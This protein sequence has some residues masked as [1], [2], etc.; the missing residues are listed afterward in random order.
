MAHPQHNEQKTTSII[1]AKL[2]LLGGKLSLCTFGKE[3]EL[4]ITHDSNPCKSRG[5]GEQKPA[6]Q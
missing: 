4:V 3:I 6:E 5:D 2:T 1:I